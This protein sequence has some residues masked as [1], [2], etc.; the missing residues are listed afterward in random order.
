M[1]KISLD[2]QTPIYE[3][4]VVQIRQ[5]INNGIMKEGDSLPT[6][7]ALA[8]Q[9][10]IANNTVAR[11]YQELES[12]GLIASG[13]RRGTFVTSKNRSGEGSEVRIFKQPIVKLLQQGFSRADIEKTFQSTIALFFD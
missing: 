6:I 9:L 7:R 8:A 11:A 12:E 13:G 1:F 3:Q 2:S 4:L 10:E 5:L